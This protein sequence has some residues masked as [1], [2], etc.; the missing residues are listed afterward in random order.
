MTQ[1]RKMFKVKFVPIDVINYILQYDGKKSGHP[2]CSCQVILRLAKP[3]ELK[4]RTPV[5]WAAYTG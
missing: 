2:V 3:I 4:L 1:T 5:G